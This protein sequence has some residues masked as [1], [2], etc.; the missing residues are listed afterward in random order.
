LSA[1]LAHQQQMASSNNA[2]YILPESPSAF[3]L[4]LLVLLPLPLNDGDAAPLMSLQ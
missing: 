4:P 1:Q 2:P 3:L